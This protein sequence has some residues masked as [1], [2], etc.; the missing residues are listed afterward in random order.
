MFGLILQ[1]KSN[2]YK[3]R[4]RSVVRAGLVFKYFTTNILL[5][6]YKIISAAFISRLFPQSTIKKKVCCWRR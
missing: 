4:E 6:E 2:I 1:S 3:G 5:V